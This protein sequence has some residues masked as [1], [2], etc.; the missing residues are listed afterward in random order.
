MDSSS[1]TAQQSTLELL[2][3]INDDTPKFQLAAC[4][5]KV[6]FIGLRVFLGQLRS[7][8]SEK[9]RAHVSLMNHGYGL[10]TLRPSPGRS[11]P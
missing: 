2:P 3:S 5:G 9:K 11:R 6:P 8:S 7:I 4:P 1:G 10:N